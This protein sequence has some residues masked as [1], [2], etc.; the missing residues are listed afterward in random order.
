MFL[1]FFPPA[2]DAVPEDALHHDEPQ[3][4]RDRAE[5]G[6]KRGSRG[7]LEGVHHDEP[8]AARDRAEPGEKRGSREG[9][10]KV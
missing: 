2:G 3:A 8:Q 1:L 9:L 10:E 7:G 4:A 6:E 5:P